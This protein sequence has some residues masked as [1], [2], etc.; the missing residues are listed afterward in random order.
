MDTGRMSDTSRLAGI[1][2]VLG[3][4]L[5]FAGTM[6]WMGRGGHAA[7]LSRLLGTARF[8]FEQ[9]FLMAAAIVTA[10]GLLMLEEYL[11]GTNGY[12]LAR[13]GAILYLFGGILIVV[14][15]AMF[16]TNAE[17][18]YPLV[19]AYVFLSLI[20]QAIIGVALTPASSFPRWI[21]WTT[22]VYSIALVVLLPI[23][24]PKDVY[25][26]F[27]QHLMPLC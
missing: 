5:L 9:G 14:D 8:G 21:A 7:D 4:A 23:L 16:L 26:P 17:H 6:M 15:I 12:G 24:S 19:V 13:L 3:F 20:G 11:R 18:I 2:L 27:A 22:I 25:Y 1:L 10:T